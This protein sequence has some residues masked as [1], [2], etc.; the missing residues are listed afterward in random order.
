MWRGSTMLAVFRI[1]PGENIFHY[2]VF[3]PNGPR[4]PFQVRRPIARAS[5]IAIQG[6]GITYLD[7]SSLPL[8]NDEIEC[9]GLRSNALG[10]FKSNPDARKRNHR[11][12]MIH[13]PTARSAKITL[14]RHSA[15]R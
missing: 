10:N 11:W 13:D 6:E 5:P 7:N 14:S 15:K 4:S 3:R 8:G 12:I 9:R 2:E 1:Q